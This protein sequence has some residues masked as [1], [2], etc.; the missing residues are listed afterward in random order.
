M[1]RGA[2][3]GAGSGTMKAASPS[4][5]LVRQWLICRIGQEDY[6]VEVPF[7]KEIIRVPE[8]TAVPRASQWL[9]GV[10]SL[11]GTVIAVVDVGCRLGLG[12]RPVTPKSRVVVLSTDRGLGGL[13]V[14]GVQELV[15]LEPQRVN[16]P[17]P[18]LAAPH[19]EL[20]RGIVHENGH[21]YILLDLEQMLIFPSAVR[22][23]LAVNPSG[24][25]LRASPHGESPC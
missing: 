7:I 15:E 18:L 21:A 23:P 8:L 3:A 16:P 5:M 20:L 6:L 1:S 14:D 17:P 10:C 12:T 11:R 2:T 4:P 24:Q 9:K 13:L 25:A 19:R 22:K